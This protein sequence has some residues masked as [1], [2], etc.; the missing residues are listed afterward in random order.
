M[1]YT[2]PE[3]TL[4]R[5]SEF[6]AGNLALH[7][8]KE[9]WNDLERN[10]AT[11][12]KELGYSEIENFIQQILSSPL[13]REHLEV[14]T[15][16]LTINE[17][18]F[19]REHDTFDALEQQILPQLI[20]LHDEEK[21]IRIWSAG[22]STGEE[23]YSIAIALNRIIPNINDWNITILASDIS[24]RILRKASA[25]EY[26]EWS[27][28]SSPQW[29]KEKYF[30][31]KEKNKFEIIPEIKNM[32][33]F[34]YLNLAEDVFPSP[35]NNTNAM[36]IIFCRNV[37]MYFTQSRVKQ[38][39][40][41]LYNSLMQ[42]GYLVVS[43]TELS[44]QNFSEFAA[45]NFS[46]MVIYQKTS[47]KLK[48]QKPLPVIEVE[49][50]P[51]LLKPFLEPIKIIEEIEPQIRKIEN[52]ILPIIEKPAHIDSTYE[53]AL[54]SYSQGN[55]TDVIN[56]LQKDDQTLEE[57]ILLT[58]AY[59]NQGKLADA[60]KSCEKAIASNKLDPRLQYLYA[61]ILQENNQ[62]DEAVASL[63][64]AIYLDTNFVLSYYSLGNIYQRLGNVNH[65]K[66][67]FENVLTILNKCS[68]EEILP[69]SEGLTAGRFK[70]II[71][72]SIRSG[73]LL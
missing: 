64:R 54:S 7:F 73:M 6:I 25:G 48:Y 69:E 17:T 26:S 33:K 2:L 9:R 30:L 47:K 3:N 13:T 55:Y 63:K 53:E 60:L 70:E 14:L 16:H 32:V 24:P 28:R 11:A 72:A 5:L 19:W 23:A 68:Q 15:N 37:L 57:Q 27:F 40:R 43:A 31:H 50:K 65:A 29:L 1:K 44:F 41:G 21:R 10:I 56:K 35:L 46:G 18:Y 51:V 66:K 39:V 38:V 62:L 4:L 61:T 52:E 42:G 36:D 45:I 59:A 71:N 12:A 49:Y 20:R 67:C 22:C 8:P 58:R 34:E